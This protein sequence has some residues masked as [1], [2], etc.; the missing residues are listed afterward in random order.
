MNERDEEIKELER[1]NARL[2]GLLRTDELTRVLNRRGFEEELAALFGEAKFARERGVRR[3]LEFTDLA[4]IFADIDNFKKI[5]DIF[6]HE[7]GDVVLQAFARLLAESVRGLD[8]IGRLGGEEFVAVLPGANEMDAFKKAGQ[9]REKVSAL[10]F[11]PDMP[12]RVTASFGVA[13]LGASGAEAFDTLIKAADVAMY[14]AKHN[15]GKNT[16]VRHS[17]LGHHT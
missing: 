13:S 9:L 3:K 1:E 6:G 2:R 5:N 12:D 4:L 11:G 7:A 17:E 14:E 8:R 16:V 15:R 10:F